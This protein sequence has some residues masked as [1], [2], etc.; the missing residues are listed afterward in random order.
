MGGTANV[1]I[2]TGSDFFIF[3][4]TRKITSE[5]LAL[6]AR[7]TKHCSYRTLQ[8]PIK[9]QKYGWE[10][11]STCNDGMSFLYTG[12]QKSSSIPMFRKS[13]REKK[14]NTIPPAF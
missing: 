9:L 11:K 5:S 8:D 1:Y 2:I 10:K 14:I 4:N 6:V 3:S 13:L 12:E 7:A